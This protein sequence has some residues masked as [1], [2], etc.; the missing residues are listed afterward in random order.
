MR[1][2]LEASATGVAAAA[3]VVLLL[4]P[5]LQYIFA[6]IAL[7]VVVATGLNLLMGLAGLLSLASAAF[8]GLGGYSVILL[9]ANLHVPVLLA[10][11]LAVALSWFVG[12]VLGFA[13]L[14]LSGFY[15]ALVTL[16]FLLTFQIVL[17][18]GGDLTGAGYGLVTPP[19]DIFGWRVP[20]QVWVGV[21]I[22]VAAVC[23]RLAQALSRARTGR[24]WRAM[25]HH[26]IAAELCGINLRREKT[27]AFA[28]SA[29]LAAL[30]GTLYAFLQGAVSPQAFSV[31]T[32]VEHLSYIVVGGMGS[33]LGSIL[34]PLVLELIPE[35][36]RGLGETRALVFGIALLSV[37]VLAPQG[38]AGL[39][40]SVWHR[41]ATISMSRPSAAPSAVVAPRVG[42]L[43][44]GPPSLHV[45]PSSTNEDAP[46]LELRDVRVAYGGLVAVDGLTFGVVRGVLHGLIGPNGAGKTTAINAITGLAPIS[47]GVV[48]LEGAEFRSPRGGVPRW[49]MSPAGIARTYQTPI[50]SPQLTA[51][52]NV[53]VGMHSRL[54]SSLFSGAL[55]FGHVE[56][57]EVSARE[58]CVAL[59]REVGFSGVADEVATGLSLGDLR[60]IELAR[61]LAQEPTVLLLDE[62]TS[63]L[64]LQAAV[65]TM[66]LLRKLQDQR[67]APLTILIVEHNVPLVFGFCDRV[68]AMDRGRTLLTGTPSDVRADTAV[69]QSYLGSLADRDE[70]AHA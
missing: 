32:T 9:V 21:A 62:P 19:A 13:S 64:E 61:A 52:E 54:S 23:A 43:P 38:L 69:R 5:F 17:R 8:M 41:R 31:S 58:R 49:R 48:R 26:E 29:A 3:L 67:E 35:L 59:L 40:G 25:K 42:P 27:A 14:R 46:H 60:R 30:A 15:L 7:L 51:V 50:V 20:P 37:L 70:A 11:P 56:R 34:G 47:Q 2:A 57:E 39:L 66:E 63:G 45:A 6:R 65:A 36:L 4:P 1:V 33:V 28:A 22:F 55:N 12:W 10:I 68:T 16:G 24:A 18:R 53:M 44:P